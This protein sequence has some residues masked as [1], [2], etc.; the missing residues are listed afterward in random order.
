M[1]T[2]KNDEIYTLVC[3]EN[4]IRIVSKKF[5]KECPYLENAILFKRL[6]NVEENSPFG[7]YYMKKNDHGQLT[8]LKD[9]YIPAI[10]WDLLFHFLKYGFTLS[11]NEN[12]SYRKR[13]NLEKTCNVCNILGGIPSFDKF[14]LNWQKEE[15]KKNNIYNPMKPRY[16][17]EIRYEWRMS[18]FF[19]FKNYPDHNDWQVTENVDIEKGG[20]NFYYRKLKEN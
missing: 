12:N 14:Y 10:H 3:R 6:F 19:N 8:L 16:D 18:A 2:M 7:K 1:S 17:T 15:D 4:L 9:F 13:E 5:L 20:N 11:Y